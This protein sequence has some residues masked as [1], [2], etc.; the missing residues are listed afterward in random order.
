[1]VIASTAKVMV[2]MITAINWSLS[3]PDYA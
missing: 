3:W 2:G 1:L